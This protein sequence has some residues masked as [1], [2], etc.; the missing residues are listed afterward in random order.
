LRLYV[1][2]L[3][4]VGFQVQDDIEKQSRRD[5]VCRFL[6]HQSK[7]LDFTPA[8]FPLA[9]SHGYPPCADPPA[10]NRYWFLKL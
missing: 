10:G 4:E 2:Q 3:I 1:D 5:W 9:V 6:R 7:A 8:F